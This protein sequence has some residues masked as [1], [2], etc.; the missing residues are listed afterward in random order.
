ML[1]GKATNNN[2]TTLSYCLFTGY[3]DT[4]AYPVP[5][6]YNP[7]PWQPIPIPKQKQERKTRTKTKS[8]RYVWNP[9]KY[10]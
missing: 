3:H 10:L 4:N 9:N 7:L 6:F 2:F 8:R 1:I 5:S